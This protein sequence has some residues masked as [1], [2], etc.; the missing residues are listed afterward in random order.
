MSEQEK[1]AAAKVYE[2]KVLLAWETPENATKI[3]FPKKNS[4][5]RNCQFADYQILER[6]P[7]PADDQDEQAQQEIPTLECVCYCHDR[8]REVFGNGLPNIIACDGFY[9]PPKE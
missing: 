8:Y 3:I 1:S 5:C 4:I 7:V 6:E 2:S 9:K